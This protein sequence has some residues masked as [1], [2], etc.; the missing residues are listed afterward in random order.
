MGRLSAKLRSMESGRVGFWC[1]GC[2]EPHVVTTGSGGWAWDGNVEAPTFSPSVL[3]TS[4]HY[5]QGHEADG[6]WCSYNA[7]RVA[8]GE[9]SAPFKCERCHSFVKA[10]QIQFLGDCTHEL[11]N[12]TVPIPDWPQS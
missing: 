8:K 12:Q 4:G 7:D 11:A 2:N 10:G 5:V 6:C 3:V 1:P 9:K